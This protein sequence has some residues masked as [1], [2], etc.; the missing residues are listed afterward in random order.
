ML[1]SIMGNKG[2]WSSIEALGVT[3]TERETAQT[4]EV[5]P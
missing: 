5:M 2:S 3:V 1:K 4:D